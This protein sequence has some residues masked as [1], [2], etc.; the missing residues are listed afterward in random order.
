MTEYILSPRGTGKAHT[1][2]ERMVEDPDLIMVCA[3]HRRVLDATRNAERA[4]FVIDSARFI[5]PG[6]ARVRGER[7]LKSQ[8]VIHDVDYL[9]EFL[10][11]GKIV[12][13][14]GRAAE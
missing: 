3:T 2:Y 13:A 8:Y 5:T 9:L 11:R 1:L 10:L 6:V 4:G 12:A 14:T 7:G